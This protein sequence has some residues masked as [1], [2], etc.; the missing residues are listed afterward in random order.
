MPKV[1]KR[2]LDAVV[3]H[4]EGRINAYRS[5]LIDIRAAAGSSGSMP[6]ICAVDGCG[7]SGVITSVQTGRPLC[8]VCNNL[9]RYD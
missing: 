7:N 9:T 5:R 8:F 6:T 3:R 2:L 1:D 4:Y